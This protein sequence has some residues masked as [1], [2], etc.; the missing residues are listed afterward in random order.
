MTELKEKIKKAQELND[1]LKKAEA[2][3]QMRAGQLQD[4]MREIFLVLGYS[5]DNDKIALPDLLMNTLI[6][7]QRGQ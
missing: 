5:K 7:G 4:L 6:E 3:V 1:E 2:M